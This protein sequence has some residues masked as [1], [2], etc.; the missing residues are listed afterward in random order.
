MPDINTDVINASENNVDTAE[1]TIIE[2]QDNGG[3]G[4]KEETIENDQKSDLMENLFELKLKELQDKDRR[5]SGAIR[6]KNKTIQKLQ[7][8]IKNKE[9]N[10][11]DDIFEN[12]EVKKLKDEIT[13]LKES[14]VNELA[15]SKKIAEETRLENKISKLSAN[16]GEQKLIRYFFDNKSNPNLSLEERLEQATAQKNLIISGDVKL[17]QE[18]VKAT[19]SSVQTKG[20]RD[21]KATSWSDDDLS[22]ANTV[23]Q[24]DKGKK[25]FEQ[26]GKGK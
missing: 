13:S 20:I 1:D 23:L 10:G 19:K 8:E 7:E 21:N 26:L 17:Q 25:M 5:L 15:E 24:T 22:F 14:V 18:I 11:N 9:N 3:D 6:E 2:G 12:E 4:V 16:E